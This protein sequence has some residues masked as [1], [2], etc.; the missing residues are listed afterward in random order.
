MI[1]GV[2]RLEL[3]I[4]GAQSLKDKRQ[5]M[6]SLATRIA[7]RF[8]VSISEIEH[9]DLRQ[10]GTLAVAHVSNT[11]HEV[12]Q[13][14]RNVVAFAERGGAAEVLRCTYSYFNPEKDD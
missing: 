11:Q 9:H 13:A 8:N 12:E 7:N 2:A 5:V 6:K 10:R 3:M 14:L 4:G 1:V